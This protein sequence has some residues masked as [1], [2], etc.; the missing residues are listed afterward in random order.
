MLRKILFLVNDLLFLKSNYINVIREYLF[1]KRNQYNSIEQNSLI[2]RKR[3]FKLLTHA[4]E[5]VP[6]YRK[7]A[8]EKKINLTLKNVFD[9]LKKFPILTKDIIRKHWN[10]LHPDLKALKY[11][12]NTSG[13]TTGEPVRIIQ[14]L[15]YQIKSYASTLMFDEIGFVRKIINRLFKNL[16]FQNA[17]KM[18]EETMIKYI[19]QINRIRP[20]NIIAYVQSI[21]ELSKLIDRYKLKIYPIKSIITSAGVLTND[22]KIYIEKIFKTKVFN[23]YGSREVG[24]IAS[25]CEKSDKLHVNMLQQFLEIIDSEGNRVREN[26]KGHIIITNLI[27]YGM[28]LIRYKIGDLGSL[29]YEQCTCGRGLIR[30]NAVH[31]RI[32]DIFGNSRK[33]RRDKYKCSSF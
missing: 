11:I 2:Q 10:E 33:N 26:Q 18:S 32:V 7:I 24:L 19:K 17:F 5:N 3:L 22:M 29:N 25:S 20:R 13:G 12:I 8:K 27:N 30:L 14:D 31:G 4:I 15:N 28:P 23:R 9:E 1:L 21:Y 16:Y 6:Y